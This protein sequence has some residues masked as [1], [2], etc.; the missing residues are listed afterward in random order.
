MLFFEEF[1]SDKP[2]LTLVEDFVADQDIRPT[3]VKTYS[4]SLKVFVTWLTQNGNV[5][6]P[7]R[8]DINA[9]KASLLT[10]GKTAL[11]I[12]S[13]M[14]ILQLF[15]KWL[16]EM[17]IYSNIARQV[18]RTKKYYG[19]RK[20]YLKAGEVKSLLEN[21][22]TDSILGLRNHAVINLMARTGLRCC[23][24]SRLCL[25]DI[26]AIQSGFILDIQR[27]GS[28][29]RNA[30]F[31]A[32]ARVIDPIRLYLAARGKVNDSDPLF[33]NHGHHQ[34][35]DRLA[36]SEVG[37]VVTLA[38]KNAGLKR[39][40]ISPHSLRHTAA[41]LAYLEG[42]PLLAISTMLG[43][44]SIETTQIYVSSISDET[45]ALNPA[46]AALDNVFD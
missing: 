4:C 25:K 31:G 10:A 15:F 11:T 8:S 35:A 23:E 36:P 40:D 19:H 34:A 29:E 3:S 37:R 42:V 38:L 41:I 21:I 9:Y 5:R 27:K 7:T 30:K 24:V 28:T 26:K 39:P 45:L 20:G 13:Y 1:M 46:V 14:R 6:T 18:H 32:T 16:E 17:Q 43:H 2:I 44:R 22:K 33:A 12:D